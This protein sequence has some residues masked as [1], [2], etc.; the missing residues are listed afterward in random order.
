[1]LRQRER[2]ADQPDADER[3]PVLHVRLAELPRAQAAGHLAAGRRL[4]PDRGGRQP[5]WRQSAEPDAQHQPG[6]LVLRQVVPLRLGGV[7]L[8]SSNVPVPIGGAPGGAWDTL[9]IPNTNYGLQA[10][11]YNDSI[12][13]SSASPFQN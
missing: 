1:V 4:Q 3:Q 11:V 13:V 7:L 10:V 8:D 6:E 5:A 2:R 12:V 9:L